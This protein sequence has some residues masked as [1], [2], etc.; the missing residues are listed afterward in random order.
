MSEPTIGQ[1]ETTIVLDTPI[2]RGNQTITQVVIRK[3]AAGELRGI[4]IQSLLEMDVESVMTALTRVTI[5]TLS[6]PELMQTDPADFLQL[7][8][9]LITFLLPKSIQ[10]NFQQS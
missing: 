7:G 1:N 5:P 8:M 4:R 3:P 6:K 2:T 10:A 9:G